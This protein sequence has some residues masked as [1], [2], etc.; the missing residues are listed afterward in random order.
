[1]KFKRNHSK[2]QAEKTKFRRSAK[3]VKFRR[4]LKHERVYDAITESRLTP[5]FNVHHCDLCSEHYENLE[6]ENFECLNKTS[7][8]LVHFLWSAH[9][10]WRKAVVNTI[11]ILKKMEKLNAK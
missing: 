6:P 3:W 1:M 9:C 7:H 4:Q 11:R 2:V 8:E 5:T 10:G